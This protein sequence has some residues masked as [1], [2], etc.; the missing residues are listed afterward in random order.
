MSINH[1]QNKRIVTRFAPS[2]TGLL[3]MSYRTGLFSFI[4]AKQHDGKFILR[5]EDTDKERSR[6]EYEANII[7][8][9]AWLGITYD[10]RYR[11]SE[12]TD[13][14]KD[15]LKRLVEK[16]FA[17]V[18][19]EKNE[20][21]GGRA[22][23]IRFKNPKQTITFN[24]LI[25]GEL[26]F[27]TT[28]L[29]DFVIAKSFDE[30]L[31]HL[32]VVVDDFEMD[33]THIIRGEDHISNT[34]RQILI[35]RAIGAPT[36]YYAHLPLIL[37]PDRTKLS[38]RHGARAISEYRDDGFLP[39]AINNFTALLGW[40]PQS[41]KGAEAEEIF[42]LD[43]LI[44]W[45]DLSH[46]QKGGAIFDEKRLFWLNKEHIKRLSP[47][48][49]FDLTKQFLPKNILEL[50]NYSEEKLKR[51]LPILTDRIEKFGDLR[52]G[53]ERGELSYLF[54]HPQLERELIPGK[55]GGGTSGDVAKTN[56]I[57][58]NIINKLSNIPENAFTTDAVKAALWDYAT[59]EGRGSVLWPLR[60][61]LSGLL[62]SP[63]PFTL[64]SYFGKNE[65]L[66]RLTAARALL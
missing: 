50:K 17:Y 64:A 18:S 45:F 16:G 58:D 43:Q 51:A 65:T 47:E 31:F 7:E 36:P 21:R 26:T 11:Q 62:K 3:N 22:E 15:Y 56:L 34:P 54:S 28:E 57:L 25:R 14:H 1:N 33:I 60:Y 42:T 29:G 32:A 61:A 38:K 19:K 53:G 40:S 59:T 46:V 12:R 2:P 48:R 4:F 9:L 24:D 35:Q 5:V 8:S 20:S 37:A 41:S 66:E 52:E 23:V 63:D 6:P 55:E 49:L 30:P 13:I 44:K 27:D 10:E 39:E